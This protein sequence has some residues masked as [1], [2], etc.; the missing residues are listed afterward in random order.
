M[1]KN[2]KSIEATMSDNN[3]EVEKKVKTEEHIPKK[4]Q[5]AYDALIIQIP[6]FND[7]EIQARTMKT[8][9]LGA[10]EVF[11]QMYPKLQEQK[12]DS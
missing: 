11:V 5:E 2:D 3:K 7:Q 4:V 9:A 6:K 10:I 8:K 12:S 1:S